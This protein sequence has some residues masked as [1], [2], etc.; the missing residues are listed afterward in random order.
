MNV[1][2]NLITTLLLSSSLHAHSTCKCNLQA[3]LHLIYHFPAG[4]EVITQAEAK[5]PISIYHAPFESIS[6][7]MWVA[8]SRSIIVNSN[9][10]RTFGQLVRSIF[11]EMHNAI[12]NEQFAEL[13][14]LARQRLISKYDYIKAVEQLEY[15][16]AYKTAKLIDQA[17]R[18]GYFPQDAFWPISTDFDTHFELQKRCGHSDWIAADYDS[19]E[20]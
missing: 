10:P 17:I 2:K 12:A 3:A 8:T 14:H 4:K 20:H 11:F 19:Y 13:D 5:G 9:H 6:N 18:E 15:E 16:N 7:A 1:I